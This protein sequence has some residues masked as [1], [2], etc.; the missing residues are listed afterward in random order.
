[1]SLQTI[2]KISDYKDVVDVL[3]IKLLQAKIDH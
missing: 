1:M 3:E 2:A